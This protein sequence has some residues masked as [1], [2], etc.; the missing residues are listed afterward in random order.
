M[1]TYKVIFTG[2]NGELS[3]L[4]D[5][6][7]QIDCS[8]EENVHAIIDIAIGI[9]ELTFGEDFRDRLDTYAIGLDYADE[10]EEI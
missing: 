2:H 8:H 7:L 3:L 5:S 1:K 4:V 6:P 9:G 10:D